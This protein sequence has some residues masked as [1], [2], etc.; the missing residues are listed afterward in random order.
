M[1]QQANEFIQHF[2]A[3]EL[4]RDNTTL[5]PMLTDDF[6]LVG[7]AGFVLGRT[8]W[9]ST[10]ASGDLQLSSLR[11]EDINVR[12]YERL[13]LAIGTRRQTGKYQE[14]EVNGEFRQ[15]LMLVKQ[16]DQW[17]LAGIHLSNIMPGR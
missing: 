17:R 7:P 1:Q 14:R 5:M 3:A 4:Q 15:T 10:L 6:Q 12:E 8:A 9:L 11:L 13:A 16:A 2:I